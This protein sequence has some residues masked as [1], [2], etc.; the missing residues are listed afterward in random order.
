MPQVSVD[1]DSFVNCTSLP[2]C[3]TRLWA[4]LGCQRMFHTWSS[5]CNVSAQPGNRDVSATRRQAKQYKSSTQGQP[6]PTLLYVSARQCIC[7]RLCSRS[8]RSRG[9]HCVAVPALTPTHEP[10]I[11][12]QHVPKLTPHLHVGKVYQNASSLLVQNP[13][14]SFLP[15]T[16]RMSSCW[17]MSSFFST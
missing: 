10:H 8:V 1:L 6:T 2:A 13:G 14:F 12:S 3:V 9:S 16:L 15:I 7:L 11:L 5:P 17:R 4:S